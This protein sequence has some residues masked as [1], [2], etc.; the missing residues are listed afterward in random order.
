MKITLKE[1]IKNRHEDTKPLFD[2]T[3]IEDMYPVLLNEEGEEITLNFLDDYALNYRVFDGYIKQF[4]GARFF[5]YDEDSDEEFDELINGLVVVHLDGWARLY[6][7]LSLQYNPL[8]NV[9]GTETHEY[10]KT[11]TTITTADRT[12]VSTSKENTVDSSFTS[13]SMHDSSKIETVLDGAIDTSEGDKHTDT[14]IRKGNIGVTKTQELLESEWKLRR[15]SF[16][17]SII[18]SIIK[19]AGFLYDE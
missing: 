2:F 11:K 19:E 6:W 1:L 18:D 9:D 17:K 15:N 13:T 16:F 10:G 7:G 12:N 5:D 14:V 3:A 4:Y 8:Y